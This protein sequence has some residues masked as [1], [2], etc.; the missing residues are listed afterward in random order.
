MEL[1]IGLLN[2]LFG[3]L[4]IFHIKDS[5]LYLRLPIIQNLD[6]TNY[7]HEIKLSNDK[8]EILEF[9]GYDT[10]IQYDVLQ[11]KSNQFIFLCSSPRIRKKYLNFYVPH[12]KGGSGFYPNTKLEKDFNDYLIDKY[13][14][15]ESTR[16][17]DKTKWINYAIK[18]FRVDNE[19]NDYAEQKTMFE[20]IFKKRNTLP[21]MNYV[22]YKRFLMYYGAINVYTWD[23]STLLEKLTQFKN[24]NSTGFKFFLG[25]CG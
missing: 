7:D 3:N 6:I 17:R 2:I 9:F 4:E 1:D 14:E 8:K 16:D 10:T 12:F 13:G 5:I 21:D 25:R 24:K 11:T 23:Q 20:D 22:I 15:K 19:L 18:F